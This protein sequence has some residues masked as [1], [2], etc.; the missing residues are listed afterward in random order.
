MRYYLLSGFIMIFLIVGGSLTESSDPS[1]VNGN[2]NQIEISPSEVFEGDAVKLKPHLGLT[3]GAVGIK[4]HGSK[5][6]ISTLYEIW[7]KGKL[8]NH[9][10]SMSSMTKNPFHGEVS[11]SLQDASLLELSNQYRVTLNATRAAVEEGIVP[12][13]GTALVNV[14]KAIQEVKAEGDEMTGINIIL[15]A[16]EEPTRAIA[17]NAGVEG[18]IIIERLKNE[19]VGIGYNAATGEWVNMFEYGIVDPAKVTRSALQNAAL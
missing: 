9:S 12:G 11:I 17:A 13:G 1:T 19:Q 6:F 15:R 8:K 18:S 14:I 2:E 4:Y 3:T 16:L 10:S 7:E 5:R